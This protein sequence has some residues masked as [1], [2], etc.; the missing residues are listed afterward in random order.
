[1]KQ[2]Q[3][4]NN[5]TVTMYQLEIKLIIINKIIKKINNMYIIM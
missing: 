5:I 1:M 2:P 3:K 4:Y